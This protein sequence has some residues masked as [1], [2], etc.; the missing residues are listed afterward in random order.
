MNH[1]DVKREVVAIIAHVAKVPEIQLTPDTDLRDDL[2]VDSLQGLQIMARLERKFDVTIPDEELD[3][4]TSVRLIVDA[5][6]QLLY[7]KTSERL[8]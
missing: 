3:M 7:E 2:N 4:Y 1:L 6:E 8:P 5:I